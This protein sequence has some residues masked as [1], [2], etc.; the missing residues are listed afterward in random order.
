MLQT[1]CICLGVLFFRLSPT[2]NQLWFGTVGS[3]CSASRLSESQLSPRKDGLSRSGLNILT[4]GVSM[5][6][7]PFQ[8]LSC[9]ESAG[10]KLP[11]LTGYCEASLT[12]MWKG[13]RESAVE[14][15]PHSSE[16]LWGHGAREQ[17]RAGWKKDREQSLSPW[18]ELGP[19]PHFTLLFP[20]TDSWWDQEGWVPLLSVPT[21]QGMCCLQGAACSPS[22]G[23]AT[24]A[25]PDLQDT[26]RL[27]GWPGKRA[28]CCRGVMV[29]RSG[30][31]CPEL[32]RQQGTA[33]AGQGEPSASLGAGV[34]SEPS[35]AVETQ[36]S[37][38]LPP[39]W[40]SYSSSTGL[41]LGSQAGKIR[42]QIHVLFEVSNETNSCFQEWECIS[43][44]P[45]LLIL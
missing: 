9:T 11:T 21:R 15:L 3:L 30:W 29:T 22:S 41:T 7:F 37:P 16:S 44:G 34:C 31:G 5:E 33:R 17:L 23:T 12:G 43:I 24:R 25:F 8:L 42:A 6:K 19:Y 39:A 38:H 45:F 18:H 26:S 36:S 32:G 4:M 28:V 35:A 1:H 20:R 14:S 40:S 10:I 13:K 27:A 2:S